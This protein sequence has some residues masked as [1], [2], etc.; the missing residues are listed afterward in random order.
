MPN[1]TGFH[2]ESTNICTLKCPGCARTRFI[3]KWPRHWMN[4]N[5]R[6]D[7]L[8]RFLD[9]DISGLTINL[10]GNYGDPIYHP[11]FINLVKSIKARDAR[12]SIDTNGS[13]KKQQWWDELCLLLDEKDQIK[14]G[15]D[16]L[17]ESF[18]Q[19]RINADWESI[20]VGMETCQK[21]KVKT[22]WKFIPFSFNQ[23]EIDIARELSHEIGID[24]FLVDPSDRYDSQTE[25]FIPVTDL[26]GPRRTAQEL[27]K[28]TVEVKVSPKCA[29]GK[30]H[31]VS[32]TGHYS[33]CCFVSDH[34]FF[35]KTQ[36]GKIQKDYDI[37]TRTFSEIMADA[38]TSQFYESI[39][40]DPH[41]V[42]QFNCPKI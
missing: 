35:Y 8:M 18:T 34:R 36:F 14:F 42:C 1:V 37:R 29:S 11:D 17:P 7:D 23:D 22:I 30:E 33:P 32:A 12:I 13:Y 24:E 2:I 6:I 19:Y 26:I 40:T 31:F 15:V 21:H 28:N 3:E 27:V 41:K 5:L 9:I 25:Q 10:C 39:S 20:K 4:H 38:N 16:G